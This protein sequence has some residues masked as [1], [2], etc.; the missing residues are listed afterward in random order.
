MKNL[1]IQIVETRG[2]QDLFL[3]EGMGDNKLPKWATQATVSA[4]AGIMAGTFSVVERKFEDREEGDL[5]VLMVA[6]LD[7]KATVRSLSVPM[8]VLSLIGRTKEMCLARSRK[9]DFL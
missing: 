8:C 7:E 9:K 1:P 5:P 2:V 4:H 6:S 3:K